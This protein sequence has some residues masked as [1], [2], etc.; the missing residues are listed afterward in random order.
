[1]MTR[2]WSKLKPSGEDRHILV[3]SWRHVYLSSHSPNRSGYGRSWHPNEPSVPGI[4]VR[5][6]EYVLHSFE[7]RTAQTERK[8]I[9]VAKERLKRLHEEQ[10]AKTK[11]QAH[12]PQNPGKRSHEL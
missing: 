8:D 11:K 10:R 5:G 9:E 7:K 3:G 6:I 12:R 1:M 2:F 4:C